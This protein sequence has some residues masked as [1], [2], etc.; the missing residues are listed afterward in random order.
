MAPFIGYSNELVIDSTQGQAIAE[1][2]SPDD[3][4]RITV[5]FGYLEDPAFGLSD[6]DRVELHVYDISKN[7]LYSDHKIEGWEIG[8]M[9]MKVGGKRTL[10]IPPELACLLYTSPSPRD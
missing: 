2:Y 6:I 9:G 3:I 10:I 7:H 5:T 4:D 8:L 1:Y